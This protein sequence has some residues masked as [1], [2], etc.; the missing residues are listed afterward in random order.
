MELPPTNL[1]RHHAHA[2]PYVYH[3]HYD[4]T[5]EIRLAA[6]QTQWLYPFHAWLVTQ[7]TE[8][9]DSSPYLLW[10]ANHQ[11]SLKIAERFQAPD[12]FPLHLIALNDEYPLEI[13]PTFATA[14]V[15]NYIYLLHRA[16]QCSGTAYL[17]YLND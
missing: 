6:F 3:K 13:R 15:I 8:N 2:S 7:T 1:H 14:Q 11:Q 4:L 9:L 10:H 12:A 16:Y 5:A 17:W